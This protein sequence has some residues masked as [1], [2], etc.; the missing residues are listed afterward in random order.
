[1][2]REENILL[3]CWPWCWSFSHPQQVHVAG[4]HRQVGVRQVGWG[5][6][7]F[8]IRH[9]HIQQNLKRHLPP[10]WFPKQHQ[11]WKKEQKQKFKKAKYSVNIHSR[12]EI[13]ILG[14]TL[15]F[16][17]TWK[18]GHL[19]RLAQTG[20]AQCWVGRFLLK[21][22]PRTLNNTD[23]VNVSCSSL[24]T[25]KVL[26]MWHYLYTTVWRLK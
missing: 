22:C 20:K 17:M 12:L 24:Q 14:I 26:C 25:L 15:D 13:Q 10:H 4:Q 11:R 18:M 1:M 21:Q 5:G 6:I 8:T 7:W 2:I 23:S 3:S 16:P 9:Q 19:Q